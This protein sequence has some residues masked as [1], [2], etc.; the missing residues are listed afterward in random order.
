[1]MSGAPGTLHVMATVLGWETE[2]WVAAIAAAALVV[3]IV[4]AI[5][6]GVSARQAA[7][8]ASEARRSNDIA[9]QSLALERQ[10]GDREV[11]DY[12]ERIAPRWEAAEPDQRGY[13][14]SNGAQ[15]EGSLR[16]VGRHSARILGA[17]LD[18]GP[19]R[20][21]MQTRCGGG[22]EDHPHVPAGAVL[23]LQCDV[24]P[25]ATD[26]GEGEKIKARP[27]IYMDY[28]APGL[29]HPPFGV[30]IELLD[31]G[32]DH[33]RRRIWRVGAVHQDVRA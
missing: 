2:T 20:T 3:S 9:E 24:A 8:S 4:A 23:E 17:A 33:R 10:R 30:T 7:R 15:L 19:R 29:S 1:M 18:V 16:N 31:K 12:T 25:V 28:E 26:G 5:F 6:A 32:T 21:R 27:M 11:V 14:N 22:W 13:F